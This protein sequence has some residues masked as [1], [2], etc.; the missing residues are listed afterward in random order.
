MILSDLNMFVNADMICCW[1]NI[2][3]QNKPLFNYTFIL[4]CTVQRN[5]KLFVTVDLYFLNLSNFWNIYKLRPCN[6]F[7]SLFVH[8]T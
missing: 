1:Y 5:K 2:S 6:D 8:K 7:D 3:Q 4:Q